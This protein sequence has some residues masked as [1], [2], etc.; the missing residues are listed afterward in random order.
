MHCGVELDHLC[1]EHLHLHHDPRETLLPQGYC[2]PLQRKSKPLY[3]EENVILGNT[4]CVYEDLRFALNEYSLVS[5][6]TRYVQ[7]KHVA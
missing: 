2:N 3:N 6:Y 5:Q 7:N 4:K 1:L